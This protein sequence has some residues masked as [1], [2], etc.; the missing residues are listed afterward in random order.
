MGDLLVT[1]MTDG[2]VAYRVHETIRFGF[3]PELSTSLFAADG[4]AL[5]SLAQHPLAG[6]Y[7]TR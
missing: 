7:A 2:D 5:P 6:A 4:R 1:L 3:A